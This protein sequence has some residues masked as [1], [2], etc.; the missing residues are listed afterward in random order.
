MLRKVLI[1]VDIDV[2]NI[3]AI[4]CI[5]FY[6]LGEMILVNKHNLFLQKNPIIFHLVSHYIIYKN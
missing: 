2:V 6:F 3:L 5:L 4:K 1:V